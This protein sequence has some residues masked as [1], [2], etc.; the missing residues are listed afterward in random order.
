MAAADTVAA[1]MVMDTV[2]MATAVVAIS[3]IASVVESS[4]SVEDAV[5]ATVTIGVTAGAAIT[6][7]SRRPL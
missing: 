4:A 1:V 7:Q 2:A 5:T 3:D 6:K